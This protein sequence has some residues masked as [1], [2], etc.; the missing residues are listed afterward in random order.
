MPQHIELRVQHPEPHHVRNL[1]P[2]VE[3]VG[4]Y[5]GNYGYALAL[6]G[7]GEVRVLWDDPEDRGTMIEDVPAAF[8][9]FFNE[10]GV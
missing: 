4:E 2:R 10:T 9:L 8:V 5:V 1:A 3:G 7:V 6:T